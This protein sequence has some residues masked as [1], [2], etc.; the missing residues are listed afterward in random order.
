MPIKPPKHVAIV[1]ELDWP[2]RRHYEIVTGVRQYA[3]KHENWT[4]QVS[5][6]PQVQMEAGMQFDG[7]VGRIGRDVWKAAKAAGIPVVNTMVGSKVRHEFHNV[8]E[9][10]TASIHRAAEHL[11]SRGI[12][13]LMHVYL[14]DQD[15]EDITANAIS[16]FTKK[17]G[18][19]YHLCI[20]PP[21]AEYNA[22]QWKETRHRLEQ[23]T[24]NIKRPIGV[25][26]STDSAASIVITIMSNIGWSI[27]HDMAVVGHGNE[28]VGCTTIEPTISSIDV[29]YTRIGYEAAKMLSKLMDGEDVPERTL[30]LPSKKLVIRGSSDVISVNDPEVQKALRYMMVNYQCPIGVPEITAETSLGR[31]TLE[32]RFKSATKKS[33][34]SELTRL[35][36]EESKRVLV[37]ELFFPIK[38]LFER[39]GFSTMSNFYAAFKKQTGM[40][41]AAYRKQY[42]DPEKW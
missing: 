14:K 20:L 27:P 8:L 15:P 30:H 36:I 5:R 13:S 4:F 10:Y 39:C 1:T 33:I 23:A 40:S 37:D 32:K 9:D 31:K 11:Y 41:P 22:D 42:A 29:G 21:K 7:F 6:F 26:C 28:E 24:K 2:L 35:R 12:R 17:R 34:Y 16:S 19:P 38:D 3:E 18:A 25:T